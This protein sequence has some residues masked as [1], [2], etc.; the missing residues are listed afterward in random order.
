MPVQAALPSSPAHA[1]SRCRADGV[2]PC[3][4]APAG[5]NEQHMAAATAW[6]KGFPKPG[7]G[8]SGGRG[9]SGAQ[10]SG[11]CPAGEQAGQPGAGHSRHIHAEDRGWGCLLGGWMRGGAVSS[12]PPCTPS[13]AGTCLS[14]GCPPLRG[15]T[16][17]PGSSILPWCWPGRAGHGS[18]CFGSV[19]LEHGQRSRGVGGSAARLSLGLPPVALAPARRCL[20]ISLNW[21]VC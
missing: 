11:V 10:G 18:L 12:A 13:S 7:A 5:T 17:Q 21:S 19:W 20:A 3:R 14:P 1:G 8:G 6:F 4:C 16:Q 15:G 2:A 9:G